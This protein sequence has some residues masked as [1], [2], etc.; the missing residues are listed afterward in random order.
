MTETSTD[1]QECGKPGH[2]YP[3]SPADQAALVSG[4]GTEAFWKATMVGCC[5][6]HA[7]AGFPAAYCAAQT[8]P[9]QW[10]THVP[11]ER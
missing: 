3:V 10:P 7:P 6:E 9:C 11:D 5:A 2:L 4:P 8:V 1:V